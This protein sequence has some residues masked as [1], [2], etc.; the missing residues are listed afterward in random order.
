M[1]GE[2][3]NLILILLFHNLITYMSNHSKQI[4]V[5]ILINNKV[6]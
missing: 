3:N 1:E 2:I 4:D 6:L 5:N